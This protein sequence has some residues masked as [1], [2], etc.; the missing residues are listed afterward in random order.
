MVMIDDKVKLYMCV[1]L[2]T[3]TAKKKKKKKG[4]EKSLSMDKIV[5]EKK[6]LVKKNKKKVL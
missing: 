4:R 5:F 3:T 2:P 1:S 6:N